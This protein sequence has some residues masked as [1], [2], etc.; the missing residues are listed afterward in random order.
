MKHGFFLYAYRMI[1]TVLFMSSATALAD[2]ELGMKYYSASNFEKAHREF[3]QAAKFGD[4]S[5]QFN[6]GVMY[7][8]G[9][10]V[11]RDP[12]QAYA[13]LA[14]AA[15]DSEYMA[16]GLHLKIYKSFSDEQKK[17]ADLAY[18]EIFSKY[19]HAAIEKNLIPELD[20]A[21]AMSNKPHLIK[22]INP[23]Y[24]NWMLSKGKMG[25]VDIFFSVDKDGTTRDHVVSYSS[26]ESFTKVTIE[27]VR[28]WQFEPF[29]IDGK[30]TSVNGQKVQFHFTL[31]DAE[32]SKRK[33]KKILSDTKEKADGGGAQEQF[34]YGYLL[35]VLPT[36]T[37]NIL[38]ANAVDNPNK[39]YLLAAQNGSPQAG[40]FLGQNM[41]NGNMCAPD[42]NK[43]MGWLLKAA[44]R[45]IIEAQYML[46]L[47]LLS[48]SRLHKNEDQGMYW[49]NKAASVESK[50]NNPAK[51]RLAWI[52]ATHP[53]KDQRD[54]SLALNY[55]RTIDPDYHDKQT[56]YRTAA[57]VYAENG[58][59]EAAEQWQEKALIDAKSLELPLERLQAQ[60]A[61]YK[62]R[63]ALRDLP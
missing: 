14:L 8:R 48:G 17:L 4:V 20:L 41:I 5:A 56:Y 11:A 45:N 51:L 39:W 32:F 44:Q 37:K 40:F 62:S 18:Q 7:Y 16:Q 25:W 63:Q 21:N 61:S 57:A 47:E 31:E 34:Q 54:G 24:P 28:K 59:F 36:F 58:N 60:L 3:R 23:D 6:L 53:N 27:A 30:T 22:Q 55:L 35:D 46:A 15:Q 1:L 29:M 26:D 50:H 42:K 52:L 19:S 12:I 33:I 38:G 10:F 2:F 49:L 9:E 43:S 13:W